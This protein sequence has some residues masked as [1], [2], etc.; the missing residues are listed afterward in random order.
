MAVLR[1][2]NPVSNIEKFWETFRVLYSSLSDTVDFDHDSMTR[3]LVGHNLVT[4]RGA[5]GDEAIRRSF[6]PNRSRDPLY[7]QLKMYSELYRMLGWLHPGKDRTHFV[8]T[9]LGSYVGEAT[10]W[11]DVKPLVKECILGITFPNPHVENRGG[12]RLRPF[13]LILRLMKACDGCVF[14][15]ELIISAL[16][17]SDD[18]KP[19]AVSTLKEKIMSIRGSYADLLEA[20]ESVADGLQNNTLRNYT[21]FPLGV[22]RSAGWA[23]TVRDSSTY[24]RPMEAYRL[25][26]IGKK[27]A[28]RLESMTDVRTEYLDEGM[29]SK[30]ETINFVLLSHY[31]ML[32]RAGYCLDSV[33]SYIS[34]VER[35]CK[36]ILQRF[37]V[38]KRS[39][40][41]FSPYQ[42]VERSLLEAADTY[43]RNT[44]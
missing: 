23:T 6:T 4:S 34:E 3:V 21:R 14:R 1:F 24:D 8:M 26:Q 12:H 37:G 20:L 2:P 11:I 10:T 35:K 5:V 42:Q 15:D 28:I 30:E 27:E 16:S 43:E 44:Y 22:L 38:E 25:T 32:E 18:R 40:I 13:P 7:N 33:E 39:G 9:H 36:A 17:L 19:D 41:L 29:F 31:S